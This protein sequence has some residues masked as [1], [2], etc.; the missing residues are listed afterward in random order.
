MRVIIFLKLGFWAAVLNVC[1]S[2]FCLAQNHNSVA[3]PP[4]IPPSPDAA[5]L[6]KYGTIPVGL[7]TGVPN[8]EIPLYTIRSGQLELPISLSYHASGIKVDEIASWVGLG[9]TLNAGGVVT[10]SIVG[11]AMT[12]GFGMQI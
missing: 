11:G 8:I 5:A 3:V 9:W 6:G 4:I 12:W 2:V 1:C 7:H 10:R